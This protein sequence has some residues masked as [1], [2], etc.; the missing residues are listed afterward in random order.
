MDYEAFMGHS[1]AVGMKHYLE[2]R[3]S[4]MRRAVDKA[5]IAGFL[6]VDVTPLRAKGDEA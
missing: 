3:H 5:D 6:D 4:D 2:A 1:F